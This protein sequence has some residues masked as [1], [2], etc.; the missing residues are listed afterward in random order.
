MSEQ[1]V[2]IKNK[3]A[4]H[5]FFIEDRY[6]AGL[7]L[8]G[9]EVKSLRSHKA[10]LVDSFARLKEGEVW[11][12]NMHISP[13]SHGN[14]HNHE[15]KRTRKLLLHKSEIR[16]LIG[17]TKE[18]GYTLVPLKV[19]FT[20]NVAKVEL[21]L[22]RGKQLFDKRRTIAEKTAKRE[23]ERAFRERQKIGKG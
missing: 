7:V 3:K 18:K 19:Y 21:G 22:A 1:L 12:H 6:E 20:G 5:N 8:T 23:V 4:E 10:N 14:I 16:R 13:Y 15:P 17:K 9:T 11:L 2:I